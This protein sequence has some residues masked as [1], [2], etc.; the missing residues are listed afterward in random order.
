[1][2]HYHSLEEVNLENSWLTI[3]SFD[4]VHRGHQ[5]IIKKLTTG[6]QHAG[7]PAVVLTFFPHPSAVV[8]KRKRFYYLTSPEERASILGS[9]GV[10]VVVTHPFNQS[11]ATYTAEEF[12]EI[13]QRQLHPNHLVVGPDF[14][15]GRGR[16]GD[17]SRLRNLGSKLGYT[18]ET[19]VPV[20]NNDEVI[21]SSRIRAA[22]TNGDVEYARSMLGRPYQISGKVIPGDGRGKSLGIP[23]ANLDI[24]KDRV[25]PKN[26]VYACYVH[27]DEVVQEAVTNIGV[28]PTFSSRDDRQWVEAHLLDYDADLY[29]KTLR[30]DFIARLRDEMRFPDLTQ[31][32]NQIH[33]D[34]M[35]AKSIL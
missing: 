4:G 20:K 1:M 7:V 8:R 13:V 11:V 10:D 12:M 34:I 6:A 2:Q 21:S 15:L 14:A 22:L 3:G 31:L 24:W 33:Q 5:E 25:I 17:V 18:L 32:I 23:T 26:G 30:L 29:G 35:E 16:E 19:V 9:L 27:I 28:R